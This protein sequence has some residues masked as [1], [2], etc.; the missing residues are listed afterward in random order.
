MGARTQIA[1]LLAA[2]SVVL[3]L[4]FL[5]GPIAD[6]PKAA[7]GAVIVSAASGLVEP[8]AWRGL[9]DTDRVELT[10]AAVT[11]AGVVAVGVLE[12]IIFAVGLSMVDVVRRSARPHD[13]VLGWV[14]RLGPG[15]TSA[16]TAPHASSRASSCIGSTTAS[17]PTR[18]T[19]KLACARR[20]AA[21]P[22]LRT[23]SS[24]TQKG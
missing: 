1:G 16:C 3:V 17:S 24:S 21:H 4:L 13:A 12:A 11:A 5:T 10:I 23:T 22:H 9:W 7:L 20:S 15:R 2:V 19:S 8:A 6:L 14:E 18:A